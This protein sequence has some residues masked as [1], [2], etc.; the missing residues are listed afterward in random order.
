MGCRRRLREFTFPLSR[1]HARTVTDDVLPYQN[2]G[3]GSSREHAALEP[4]FLGGCAIIT[5]SFARIHETNCKKQGLLPLTF[6]DPADYDRVQPTD[7]VDLIG[8]ETLAP[9][10]T[11]TMRLHHKEYVLLPPSSRSHTDSLPSPSGSSEDIKLAHSFN[12]GQIVW[13]QN[14]SALNAMGNAK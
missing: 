12:A 2:Y 11:I 5:R 6:A 14:G 8:V 4:R 3:E 7:K 13:Y 9:E 1:W 10:S